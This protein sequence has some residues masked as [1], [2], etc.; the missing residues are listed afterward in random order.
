MKLAILLR[1]LGQTIYRAV[2]PRGH[3]SREDENTG[4]LVTGVCESSFIL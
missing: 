4:G 3:G 2:A 1:N